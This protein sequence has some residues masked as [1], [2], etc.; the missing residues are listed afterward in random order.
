MLAH[1]PCTNFA[2]TKLFVHYAMHNSF[3]YR[4]FNSNFS[5]GDP[6]FLPYELF[7]SR[8]RGA[9]GH[10]VHLPRAWKVLDDYSSSLITLTTP[11]YIDICKE[12]LITI[13]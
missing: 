13:F 6:T 5:C 2:I 1:P 10:S 4:Q 7:H 11:E 8:N 12:T 9:V 3:A